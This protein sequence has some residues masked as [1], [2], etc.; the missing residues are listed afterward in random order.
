MGGFY[1]RLVG[2]VKRSLRKAIGRKLLTND[3]LLTVLK[4]TEA[5]VNS[6]PLVYIGDDINSSVTITPGNFLCLN[7]H[8]G[9]PETEIAA[10]PSYKPS[11]SSAERLLQ[12]WQKGQRL[13]DTFWKVWRD[14]YL[15]SLRE[16]CQTRLKCQRKQSEFSPNVGDVVLIKD[17][18]PRGNWK[19]GKIV[20]LRS[21]SGGEI[22]SARVQTT[23]GRV[24]GRPLKL[25]FP[26][27][28]SGQSCDDT[29]ED[30]SSM[31]D[32]LPE[33]RP[34]RKVSENARQRIKDML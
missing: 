2:L 6:R 3:Q 4:E 21:S 25:L 22:R 13:L 12:L 19:F 1:E 14:D 32:V 26:I 10:D 33:R 8:T 24:I 17:D 11:E 7:Q 5:V 27:E 31:A 28:V 20:E 15:L 23:S 18:V 34:R 9:I 30:T 16:R 29:D